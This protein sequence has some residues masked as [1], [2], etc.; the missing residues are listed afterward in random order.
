MGL[1]KTVQAISLLVALHE[2]V[3]APDPCPHLIVVPLSVLRNWEKEL[4]VGAPTFNV[5][6]LCGTAEAR[7]VG[8]FFCT[9]CLCCALAW[10]NL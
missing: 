6:S 3:R 5:V 10:K 4:A 2:E 9:L 1:G 7:K 8:R